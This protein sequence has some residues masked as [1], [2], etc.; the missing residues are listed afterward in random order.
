M[1]NSPVNYWFLLSGF[2]S[3]LT[4]LSV[5]HKLMIYLSIFGEKH[6]NAYLLFTPLKKGA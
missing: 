3:E 2:S 5:W 6:I 1:V 4:V